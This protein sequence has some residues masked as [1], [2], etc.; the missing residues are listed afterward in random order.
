MSGN[1]EVGNSSPLLPSTLV[2]V[3]FSFPHI[4]FCL[5][6]EFNTESHESVCSPP[7]GVGFYTP[8]EGNS[9]DGEG[10]AWAGQ[11][12]GVVGFRALLSPPVYV[13]PLLPLILFCALLKTL[14]P[15]C[16]S[17]THILIH[18]WGLIWHR[19]LPIFIHTNPWKFQLFLDFNILSFPLSFM[20]WSWCLKNT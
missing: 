1:G 17:L 10:G 18:I 7:V 3:Y 13:C 16:A 19:H 5:V 6:N 11:W 14:P 12:G 8:T 4:R 9:A 20:C 15:Y 2:C